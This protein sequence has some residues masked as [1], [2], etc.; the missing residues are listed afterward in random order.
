MNDVGARH[1]GGQNIIAVGYTIPLQMENGLLTVPLHV[2]IEDELF[3]CPIVTI[4]SDSPRNPSQ[5]TPDDVKMSKLFAVLGTEGDST[6]LNKI[7]RDV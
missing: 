7:V 2:S 4:S 1:G 5:I 3:S 6:N